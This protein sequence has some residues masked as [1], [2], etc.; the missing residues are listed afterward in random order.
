MIKSNKTA[1]KGTKINKTVTLPEGL[2][3]VY[4]TTTKDIYIGIRSQDSTE[5]TDLRERL[6]TEYCDSYD[7]KS[8]TY[9]E[10]QWYE[11][12]LITTI[13]PCEKVSTEKF[14]DEYIYRADN[15]ASIYVKVLQDLTADDYDK[16]KKGEVLHFATEESAN[17]EELIDIKNFPKVSEVSGDVHVLYS[18]RKNQIYLSSEPMD[19]LQATFGKEWE[20]AVVNPLRPQFDEDVV[21]RNDYTSILKH[22]TNNDWSVI[23]SEEPLNLAGK[24]FQNKVKKPAIDPKSI[25]VYSI[26]SEMEEWDGFWEFWVVLDR[27]E[28]GEFLDTA[29]QGK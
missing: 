18:T 2:C 23:H 19:E 28:C 21:Q 16:L 8:Q 15:L 14:I 22:L 4:G 29:L 6:R 26:I 20:S 12:F 3:A 25:S 13:R 24:I 10:G 17:T 5:F 9:T 11:N 7:T 27:Y 1:V